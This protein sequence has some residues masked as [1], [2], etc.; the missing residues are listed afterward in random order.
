MPKNLVTSVQYHQTAQQNTQYVELN[1]IN[2]LLHQQSHLFI[3]GLG[4]VIGALISLLIGYHL[5]T[6]AAN[7][8]LLSL[9]PMALP[10]LLREVYIY[11]LVH[12]QDDEN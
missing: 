10:Y 8:A 1:K 6:T 3:V 11:T 9:I 4:T 5:E 2:Q 7:I 12:M